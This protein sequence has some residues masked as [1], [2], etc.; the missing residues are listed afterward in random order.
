[1]SIRALLLGKHLVSRIGMA[2]EVP[3]PSQTAVAAA[4]YHIMLLLVVFYCRRDLPTPLTCQPA[5]PLAPSCYLATVCRRFTRSQPHVPALAR[6]P[7]TPLLPCPASAISP[8]CSPARV[9][10]LLAALSRTHRAASPQEST[11]AALSSS[12]APSNACR[13]ASVRQ[14]QLQGRQGA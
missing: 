5:S 12:V 6:Q 2:P 10:P 8:L 13:D 11:P 9:P 14:G 7:A 3:M 1:M 4:S